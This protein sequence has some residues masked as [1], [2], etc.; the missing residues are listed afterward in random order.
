MTD[1]FNGRVETACAIWRG[2]WFIAKWS[3]I[4]I[5]R[6]IRSGLRGLCKVTRRAWPKSRA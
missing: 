5:F 2:L 6:L 1:Y 4:G 3:G